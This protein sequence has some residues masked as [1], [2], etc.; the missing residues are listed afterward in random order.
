MGLTSFTFLV[1]VL[2]TLVGY[3]IVPKKIKWLVLLV[4]SL[5]FLFYDNLTFDIVGYVLI[6]L[7][8]AYIF[9]LLIDKYKN[10]TKK[11]KILVV[12]SVLIILGVLI[13]LKYTNFI[14]I[15]IKHIGNIFGFSYK[16]Q[17]VYR[18][19]PIG[20]S[21]FSLIMISYVV[22]VYRGLCKPQKNILKC[23]LF[24]SYFPILTSGPFIRY[25]DMNELYEPHKFD[26]DRM[27]RGLIRIAWGVF[28]ILVISERLAIF[29]NFV[30]ANYLTYNGFY[31]AL[32]AI[33]FLLQLYTNFSGSIDIIMGIS[34]IIGIDLP[35]NFNGPFFSRSVT[36]LWRR[37]HITLGAWLKDYVFYPLQKS[38]FIQEIGRF[39]KKIFGKKI[40]KKIML[41]LAMLIMWILI[42]AWHNGAYT[43]II[44]SGILQ[45]IYIFLEDML[46]P[47]GIDS[48]TFG[49]KLYQRIRTFLLF[50]L[51]MIFFSAPSV[52][53]ALDIIRNMFVWNPW[54]LFDN[55]SLYL[56]GL[57]LYDFRVLGLAIIVLF[58]VDYY[59]YIGKD[60]T[61]WLFKQNI[62]FRWIIIYSLL[63]AIII[64]GCYGVGYNPANFIYR[65]F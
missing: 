54:I 34:K 10:E 35:E 57:D 17:K 11:A 32:A 14:G 58:V 60:V 31:I 53:K 25:K 47:L 19:V 15:T 1:F 26:Y 41:Y 3:F 29:V 49:Y 30:Y 64:F 2:V 24:M 37:W 6:I 39:T 28:K 27:C 50:A 21:Y 63:F 46:T 16:F 13:F 52:G 61:S 36:E 59:K 33:F 62:V 51:A 43:F 55:K 45:F 48:E 5:Y 40:S 42:G 22:D 18:N 56:C 65:Q 7:L 9:A 20:I 23:A 8:V 44:G 4:S 38:G 12:L